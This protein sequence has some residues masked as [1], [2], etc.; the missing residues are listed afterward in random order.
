[1]RARHPQRDV[2]RQG[3]RR[4]GPSPGAHSGSI[5]HLR[6]PVFARE[7]LHRAQGIP[8]APPAGRPATQSCKNSELTVERLHATN[9]ACAASL[10]WRYTSGCLQSLKC[11]PDYLH[12][13]SARR[14]FRPRVQGRSLSLRFQPLYVWMQ[15]LEAPSPVFPE[16]EF[17]QRAGPTWN[18]QR[19]IGSK[20]HH[21]HASKATRSG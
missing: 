16:S 10:A 18:A 6:P 5:R 14:G 4:D 21:M 20:W 7:L 15:H 19:P 13:K 1:M 12:R 8:L 3:W 17:K 11:M 2:C 9:R